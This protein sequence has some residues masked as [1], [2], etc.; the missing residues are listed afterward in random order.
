MESQEQVMMQH[1]TTDP[2][3]C[4]R[5]LAVK[6]TELKKHTHNLM[7]KLRTWGGLD[8]RAPHAHSC[9]PYE[10]LPEGGKKQHGQ[11]ALAIDVSMRHEFQ[12]LSVGRFM[13]CSRLLVWANN[14][15]LTVMTR[16]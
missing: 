6:F 2:E 13:N 9:V 4:R 7:R 10:A 16:S 11:A 15:H 14:L 3:M 12:S 5:I 1:M 8:P